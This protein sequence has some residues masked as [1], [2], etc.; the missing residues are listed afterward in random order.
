LAKQKVSVR[1]IGFV[2]LLIVVFMAVFGLIILYRSV[3]TGN[4]VDPYNPK[5]YVE[6]DVKIRD[7]RLLYCPEGLYPEMIGKGLEAQM[8]AGR[9][10]VPSPYADDF[11]YLKEYYCCAPVF[12]ERYVD[13]LPRDP[14][15]HPG[16]ISP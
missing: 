14:T 2:V 15:A 7:E 8:N 13:E 16:L 1:N 12:K 11:P 10:C 4:Y 5:V 3:A 9:Y 6:N